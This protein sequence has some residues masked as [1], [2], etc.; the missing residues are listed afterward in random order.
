MAVWAS[1]EVRECSKYKDG[2]AFGKAVNLLSEKN[3]VYYI[4][5]R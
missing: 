4:R 1:A 5:D 2:F 3:V